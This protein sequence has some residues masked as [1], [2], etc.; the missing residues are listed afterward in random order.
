MRD[1]LAG[2][3]SSKHGVHL[4]AHVMHVRSLYVFLGLTWPCATG[5]PRKK[6]TGVPRCS[7][8]RKGRQ[9]HA[10]RSA[11]ILREGFTPLVQQLTMELTSSAH[12][13][14]LALQYGR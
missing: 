4:N 6:A 11:A 1:F 3:S 2:A 10:T 9:W 14:H 7:P 8:N 12:G 13:A 5:V